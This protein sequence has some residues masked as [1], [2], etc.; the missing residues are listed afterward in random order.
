M[1]LVKPG[2]VATTVPLLQEPANQLGDYLKTLKPAQLVKTMHLSK[3]LADKTHQLLNDWSE[4]GGLALDSFIGDIYR[5][6]RA[7]DLSPA[8]RDYASKHLYILSGLYGVLRPY[9]AIKPYRLEMAYKLP[10]AK[11]SN[12]YQFWGRQIADALPK[13]QLIVN[14][15][16]LEYGK[17]VLPYLDPTIIITPEFLSVDPKS[18]QTGFVAVHAKVARGA[19]ARWMV[20][21]QPETPDELLSFNE[22]GYLYDPALSTP[23]KPTFVCQQFG[24][25]GL[26]V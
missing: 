18:S 14:V 8:E 26:K 10:V 15:S 20:Q 11:F 1:R 6:L 12:L 19:F 5:G 13:D 21:A 2:S 17:A 7:S 23:L 22:L 9:D 25:L 4:G 3:P 16:S 24:G